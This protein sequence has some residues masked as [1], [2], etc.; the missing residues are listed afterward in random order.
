MPHSRPPRCPPPCMG[1]QLGPYLPTYPAA[2]TQPPTTPRGP[3]LCPYPPTYPAA[4]PLPPTPRG[5]CPSDAAAPPGHSVPAPLNAGAQGPADTWGW[6]PRSPP[7]PCTVGGGG[8]I[9]FPLQG[10]LLTRLGAHDSLDDCDPLATPWHPLHI[11]R[12]QGGF[13]GRRG[14]C[15]EHSSAG[16]H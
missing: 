14:C 10:C 12:P 5:A 15:L 3:Q 1:P 11:T 8:S 2:L 7:G 16:C 9:L 4:L 6:H 13:G